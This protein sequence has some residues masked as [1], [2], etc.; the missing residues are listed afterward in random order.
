MVDWA[1]RSREVIM[2]AAKQAGEDTGR[3][4]RRNWGKLASLMGTVVFLGGTQPAIAATC[5][6][7]SF[8]DTKQVAGKKLLLNGLG[9]R[10]ATIFKVDVYVAA[11]Y[12]EKKSSDA[13]EL[14]KSNQI[15]QMA[16]HLVRN[17]TAEEL[18]DAIE[19]GFK[20][21][22][23]ADFP[24]FKA[25]MLLFKSKVPNLKNGQEI[26]LTMVPKKGTEIIFDGKSRGT[27][28]GDDFAEVLLSLWIGAHPPNAGLKKGLLG[29]G[30]G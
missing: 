30:C 8:A 18:N 29:K 13:Q 2:L 26:A 17:V 11:L 7:Q 15:R 6:G 23:G 27:V 25:R 9:V 24:K 5:A 4:T 16:L 3:L 1:E 28:A 20:K 22:T 19:D 14:I 21:A 10:E 12:V